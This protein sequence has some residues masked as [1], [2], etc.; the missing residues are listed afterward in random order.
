MINIFL[1]L[2]NVIPEHN[3]YNRIKT[4]L[5]ESNIVNV[6]DNYQKKKNSDAHLMFFSKNE[7]V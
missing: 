6:V 3:F 5:I 7:T 1:A 4:F 2:L